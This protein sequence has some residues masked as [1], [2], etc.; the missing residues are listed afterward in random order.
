MREGESA[1]KKKKS[2]GTVTRDR[3]VFCETFK[4]TFFIEPSAG[5][6]FCY[7]FTQN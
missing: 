4:R 6:Y 2:R 3:R 5:D 7:L 1:I